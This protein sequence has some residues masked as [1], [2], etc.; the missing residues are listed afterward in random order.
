MFF[1]SWYG[2]CL[3][4][5]FNE[6]A[7]LCRSRL[8]SLLVQTGYIGKYNQKYSLKAFLLPSDSFYRIIRH[9]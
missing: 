4:L 3:N 7:L 9:A 1:S 6:G 8:V 2:E 5:K